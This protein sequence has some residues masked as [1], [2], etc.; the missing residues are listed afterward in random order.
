MQF[1]RIAVNAEGA[2]AREL[3][4]AVSSAQQSDTQ[5]SRAAC[6]QQ[7]PNRIA[8]DIAVIDRYAQPLLTIEKKIRRRFSTHHVAALDDDRFGT[9]AEN[10]ERAIDLGPPPGSRDPM[11][12]SCI[13]QGA[14]QL[15][16][17]GKRSPLRKKL[18]KQLSVPPL[19]PL[20]LLGRDLPA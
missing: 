17:A 9:D 3:V 16:R 8:H 7:I 18:L 4:L 14:K 2:G 5:H 11:R 6:G 12:Y 15:R 10:V 13:P 20:G 19:K 1:G